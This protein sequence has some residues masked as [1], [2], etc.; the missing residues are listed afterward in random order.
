MQRFLPPDFYSIFI[1]MQ[2]Q[3]HNRLNEI[4]YGIADGIENRMQADTPITG[5]PQDGDPVL[6]GNWDQ[7][8]AVFEESEFVAENLGENFRQAFGAIK[9][10]EQAEFNQAVSPLEYN[11]YLVLA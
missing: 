3:S 6:P 1:D 4:L 8:L 11:S 5:G 9:R 2:G 7:A 10:A